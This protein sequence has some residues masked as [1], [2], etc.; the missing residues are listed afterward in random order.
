M[1]PIKHYLINKKAKENFH[2]EETIEIDPEMTEMVQ[3]AGKY[4]KAAFVNMVC[5]HKHCEGWNIKYRK[6]K[7]QNI[8]RL[9]NAV[10]RCD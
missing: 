6:E 10:M 8:Q 9:K 5:I 7:N 3:L 1:H 2:N 4:I